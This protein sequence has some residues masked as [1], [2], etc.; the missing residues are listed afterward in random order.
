MT[1][2]SL[3]TSLILDEGSSAIFATP[4]NDEIHDLVVI[5]T[6]EGLAGDWKRP[7]KVEK[8]KSRRER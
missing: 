6:V 1:R 3:E 5:V 4:A 8:T 7:G 2:V